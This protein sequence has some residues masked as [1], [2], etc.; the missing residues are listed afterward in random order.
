MRLSS[1][2]SNE[3]VRVGENISLLC[4]FLSLDIIII[5]Y[6]DGKVVIED[7]FLVGEEGLLVKIVYVEDRGWYVCNVINKVGIKLV[8]VYVYVVGFGG[9]NEG[10]W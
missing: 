8:W 4:F 1:I 2:L 5:W 7:C 9:V 3:I 10:K 6:K